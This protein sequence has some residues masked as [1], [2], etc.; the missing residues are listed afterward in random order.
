MLVGYIKKITD[1]EFWFIYPKT[2]GKVILKPQ[3]K[4]RMQEELL[5]LDG[6]KVMLTDKNEIVPME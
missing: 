6:K 3:E 1:T 5:M 2:Q 4:S